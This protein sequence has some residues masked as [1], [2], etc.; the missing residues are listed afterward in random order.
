MVDKNATNYNGDLP[1]TNCYN[2]Q[3]L[4][5]PGPPLGQL[6]PYDASPLSLLLILLLLLLLLQARGEELQ[7]LGSPVVGEHR[8]FTT[9]WVGEVWTLRCV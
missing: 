1:V 7:W 8:A 9:A 6:P 3:H 4:P 2:Y 5:W